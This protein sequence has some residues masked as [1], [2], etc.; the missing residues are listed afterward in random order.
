MS[1]KG[2]LISRGACFFCLTLDVLE[3][4][5]DKHGRPYLRCTDCLTRAFL[6]NNRALQGPRDV[7]GLA[8]TYNQICPAEPIPDTIKVKHA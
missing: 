4:R 3:L 7:W 6:Y 2:P 8:V 5:Q 1:G